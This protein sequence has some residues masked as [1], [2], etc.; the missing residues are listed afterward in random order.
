MRESDINKEFFGT[1]SKESG[2]VLL[3]TTLFNYKIHVHSFLSLDSFHVPI[4]M[5][6]IDGHTWDLALNV[7]RNA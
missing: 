2:T 5:I 4:I 3:Y 7:P 1:F 6:K